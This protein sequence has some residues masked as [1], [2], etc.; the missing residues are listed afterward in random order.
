MAPSELIE[1]CRKGEPA[2]REELFERYR[3]YLWLLAQAQL[4]RYLRA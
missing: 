4:G 1:R 3:H 2:A